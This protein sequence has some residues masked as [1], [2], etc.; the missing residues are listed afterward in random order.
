MIPRIQRRLLEGCEELVFT[1]AR[2]TGYLVLFLCNHM[3]NI[4]FFVRRK[5]RHSND[6]IGFGE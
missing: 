5:F 4:S 6:A 2:E 1:L 3:H